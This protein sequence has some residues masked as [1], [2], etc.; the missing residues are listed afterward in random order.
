MCHS[1]EFHK[2][3]ITHYT[4]KGAEVAKWICSWRRITQYIKR[5]AESRKQQII[6]SFP[7][8]CLVLA[9]NHS[10]AIDPNHLFWVMLVSG[11]I[12]RCQ[13]CTGNILRA[14]NGK[15]LPPPEDNTKSKFCFRIPRDVFFNC[16]I[17]SITMSVYL[18]F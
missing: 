1:E 10:N 9:G 15:P 18:V 17:M 8:Y 16:P 7:L 12:S 3:V 5:S 2:Y 14:V 6:I 11:N 4:I 13:K